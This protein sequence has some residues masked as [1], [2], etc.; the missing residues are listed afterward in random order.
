LSQ[1]T[2][3][4][5]VG[6]DEIEL[7]GAPLGPWRCS[8]VM[9][10][11]RVLSVAMPMPGVGG[12]CLGR[13]TDGLVGARERRT[14]ERMD[15]HSQSVDNQL[16]VFAESDFRNV[17]R[18][19]GIKRDD[20]RYHMHVVGKTGMGKSTLLQTLIAADIRAG[21]GLALIDPHGDLAGDVLA[22]C[23]NGRSD[24]G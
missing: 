21:N 12:S 18:R 24:S 2:D 23:P 9:V 15:S 6:V 10:N 14:C 5:L 4:A 11:N 17:R 13:Q 16:T 7:G 20:R 3:T 22:S 19:F 8:A 1:T